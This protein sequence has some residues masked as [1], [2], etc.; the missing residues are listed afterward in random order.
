VPTT[1]REIFTARYEARAH[2]YGIR[3][4]DLHD[5]VDALQEHA[6]QAAAQR[7]ISQAFR[8]VRAGEVL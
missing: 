5:A 4:F 7:I 2:L 3:E 1:A 8:A 6:V